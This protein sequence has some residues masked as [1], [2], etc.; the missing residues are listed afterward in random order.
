MHIPDGYLG[1]V[2]AGVL[3]GAALP[4]WYA[5]GRKM[6]K[7]LAD[8]TLPLMA[9]LSAFCFVIQMINIPL[10]GGTTGHATG[11]SLAAIVLGPW[12]AILCVSTTVVIQALFFGDGGITAIGA[13]C[14]N[15]AV[16][17]V[18]V[19]RLIYRALFPR[20]RSSL[21]GGISSYMAVN[22]AAVAAGIELGIQ[23]LIAHAPDGSPLYAPYPPGTAVGA[24]L[25]G[26]LVI[27]VA[28]AALTGLVLGYL[29]RTRPDMLAEGIP[30]LPPAAASVP[31]MPPLWAGLR[32]LWIAVAFL[33]FLVPLGLMAPGAGW[34][35][36]TVGQLR[37]RGFA[38]IPN[39]IR[40]W[41][42]F[43]GGLFPGYTVPGVSRYGGY[44][45]SAAAGV[46]LIA[47]VFRLL[48][49]AG[50]AAANRGQGRRRKAG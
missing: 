28:E 26:H 30:A 45:L 16:L 46:A 10:F 35:E 2:T 22:A 39:G 12:P 50:R 33:V 31:P 15:M 43:W 27:G 34:G 48:G 17:Q 7:A 21:A 36:W 4:F 5:A 29:A 41:E 9:L 14:F 24:M 8:R 20:V 23:P 47:V 18:L 6:R 49:A 11:A 37:E 19:T 44:I 38:F 13:N 42:G 1:P 3:Y 32:T 40:R 25:A